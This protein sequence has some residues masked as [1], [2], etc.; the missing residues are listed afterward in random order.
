MR[1]P[2]SQLGG[3]GAEVH[4][5]TAGPSPTFQGVPAQQLDILRSMGVPVSD[6]SE[7]PELP[8]ADLIVDAIIGYS[9][10]GAP[11]GVAAG[12]ILAANA[13]G[14]PIL[15]LDVPSGVDATTG[16]V[17]DP[18]IRATATLTLALPK[19]GLDSSKAIPNVGEL[20][21]ADISVPRELYAGLGIGL[22]V[23]PIFAKDDIVRLR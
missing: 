23:G 1:P 17:Y 5:V 16:R 20:Y 7:S 22:T 6:G 13:H 21:L 4:V 14:A 18:A 11:T 10:R 12:L 2:P 3:G 9:L 8:A 19:T 15:S